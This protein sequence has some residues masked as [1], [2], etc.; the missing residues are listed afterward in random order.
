MGRDQQLQ[1]FSQ[2]KYWDRRYALE[3][4]PTAKEID[5]SYE[6]FGRFDKIKPILKKHLPKASR[7]PK[8]LHLGVGH[9]VRTILKLPSPR[10]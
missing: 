9:S 5:A 4:K 7:Q 8:I 6:W 2:R 3:R 10:I 1:E